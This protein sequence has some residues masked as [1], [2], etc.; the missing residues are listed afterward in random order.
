[1]KQVFTEFSFD[2]H[3]IVR[4]MGPARPKDFAAFAP[5]AAAHAL[6]GDP[7]GRELMRLAAGHIASLVDR[8]IALGASR[9][10]LSGGLAASIEPWLDEKSQRCL[11]PPA[12]DALTG[13]VDLARAAFL[14]EAAA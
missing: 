6:T 12:A 8:L 5:F 10:A 11:V 7:V 4:W 3:A 13:A 1:L 2:P 9:V 14:S